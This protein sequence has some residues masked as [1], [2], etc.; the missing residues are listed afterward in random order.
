[1]EG[2]IL[3]II[4][5]P[6]QSTYLLTYRL[7]QELQATQGALELERQHVITLQREVGR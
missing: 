5:L 1:M 3:V 2:T 6:I 7:H 4:H